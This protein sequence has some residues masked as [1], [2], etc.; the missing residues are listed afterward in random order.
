MTLSYIETRM[1]NV[2]CPIPKAASYF[3]EGTPVMPESASKQFDAYKATNV[4]RILWH[5]MS[6]CPADRNQVF[7]RGPAVQ[8]PGFTFGRSSAA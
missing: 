2:V 6:M 1:H 4:R 3:L 7:R 5:A 8:V